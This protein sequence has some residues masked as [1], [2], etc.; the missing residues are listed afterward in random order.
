MK[1]E[2]RLKRNC[3]QPPVHFVPAYRARLASKPE[4]PKNDT[5]FNAGGLEFALVLSAPVA[6]GRIV[7]IASL[8][9]GDSIKEILLYL[10]PVAVVA[11]GAMGR[12]TSA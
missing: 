5:Q 11:F 4:P 6:L 1:Y 8:P 12:C 7:S 9:D 10:L 2:V 3:P